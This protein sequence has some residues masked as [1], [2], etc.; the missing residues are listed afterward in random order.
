MGATDEPALSR[1]QVRDV[2]LRERKA[3]YLDF[4]RALDFPEEFPGIADNQLLMGKA[5][6]TLRSVLERRDATTFGGVE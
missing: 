6:G 3:I 2:V 4:Q 5:T 1:R